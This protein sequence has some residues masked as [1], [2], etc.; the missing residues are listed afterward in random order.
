MKRRDIDNRLFVFPFHERF[1]LRKR[2]ENGEPLF[3][4]QEI[5]YSAPG[6]GGWKESAKP[7]P[8]PDLIDNAFKTLGVER[9]GAAVT[10]VQ[11]AFRRL[12]LVHH[13]DHGGD[14]KEFHRIKAARDECL[15]DLSTMLDR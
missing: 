8:P 12:A 6:D 5:S 13:P 11:K 7:P 15:R 3:G 1:R 4:G 2:L 9:K 14:V 10:D